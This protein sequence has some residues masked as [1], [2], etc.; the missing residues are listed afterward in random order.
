MSTIAAAFSSDGRTLAS[1]H[2]DH[3]VKIIDCQ[4]GNCLKVLS[5]HRR[6][7]CVVRFHP[8]CSEILAS[9]SLDHEVRLWDARTADCIGSS[10]CLYCFSC[11]R[12]N[13]CCSFRSQ[14]VHMELQQE[15]GG[16]FPNNCIENSTIIASSAFSSLCCSFP[17]N[18]RG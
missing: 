14:A 8:L 17:T 10:N 6:T 2:G 13:S 15:R 1:T 18:G 7:P 9:G 16:F 12:R 11:I 3:T 4:T 5:G